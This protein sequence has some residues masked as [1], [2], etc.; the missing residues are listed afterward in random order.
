[1]QAGILGSSDVVVRV[2][3]DVAGVSRL[4]AQDVQEPLE[5]TDRRLSLADLAAHE[6]GSA[7]AG[8][9]GFTLLQGVPTVG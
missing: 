2:I 3:S 1:L 5:G 8:L 6:D 4:R 9:L 7:E